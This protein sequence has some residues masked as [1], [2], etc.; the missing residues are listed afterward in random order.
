MELIAYITMRSFASGGD[1][2]HLSRG[3]G[4][5]PWLIFIVGNTLIIFGLSV[6]FK[7]VLPVKYDLFAKENVLTS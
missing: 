1:T 7:N 3:L 6:L 4:L 5:S 2:G